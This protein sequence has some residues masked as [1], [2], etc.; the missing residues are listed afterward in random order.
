MNKNLNIMF[1]EGGLRSTF[2]ILKGGRLVWLLFSSHLV[3]YIGS[4]FLFRKRAI[5]L[6]L[7]RKRKILQKTA[8]PRPPFGESAAGQV[9][10]PSRLNG[11][12][13]ARIRH[14]DNN[15]GGHPSG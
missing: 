4:I 5:T 15:E 13:R 7:F 1:N 14:I 8:H 2:P 11:E 3:D 6:S 12:G 10:V 9:A